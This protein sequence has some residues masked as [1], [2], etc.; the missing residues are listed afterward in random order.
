[1]HKISENSMQLAERHATATYKRGLLVAA[2]GKSLK[3][4]NNFCIRECG[5]FIYEQGLLVQKHA[6][7]SLIYAVE[8]STCDF[9]STELYV[10]AVK[11]RSK[12]TI[13][14][15]EAV[16]IYTKIIQ[17]KHKAAKIR[18]QLPTDVKSIL[19]N[20]KDEVS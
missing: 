2:L 15:S 17:G 13:L 6:R 16:T 12:A 5:Q 18:L 11:A 20:Y 4:D 8:L 19:D 9:S 14:Y 7:E 3:R 1:M 10:K